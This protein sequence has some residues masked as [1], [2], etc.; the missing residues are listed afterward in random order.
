[1]NEVPAAVWLL[2]LAL[3]LYLLFSK[4]GRTEP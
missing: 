3:G 1:M 4:T 2:V